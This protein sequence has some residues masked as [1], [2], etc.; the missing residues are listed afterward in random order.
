MHWFAIKAIGGGQ[1]RQGL[2]PRHGP[3]R[4]AS[5]GRV[6]E[7][8]PRAPRARCSSLC[9]R[10]VAGTAFHEKLTVVMRRDQ[11]KQQKQKKRERRNAEQ[12]K[13]AQRLERRRQYPNIVFDSTKGDPEFVEAVQKR[14]IRHASRMNGQHHFIQ[15]LMVTEFPLLRLGRLVRLVNIEKPG[16]GWN[17]DYLLENPHARLVAAYLL[18]HPPPVKPLSRR[19]TIEAKVGRLIQNDPAADIYEEG[20]GPDLRTGVPAP[21]VANQ[22]LHHLLPVPAD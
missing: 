18:R 14:L 8:L 21:G 2:P 12:K 9:A 16:D 3:A 11:R 7:L 10:P 1:T 15:Q 5:R 20:L 13:Y 4:R 6:S 17:V 22:L 19:H